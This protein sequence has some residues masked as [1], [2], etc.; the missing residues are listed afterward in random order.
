MG[1][2]DTPRRWLAYKK[3]LQ[4]NILGQFFLIGTIFLT[5]TCCFNIVSYLK[6]YS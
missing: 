3:L 4:N 2:H 1:Y 6:N 5:T